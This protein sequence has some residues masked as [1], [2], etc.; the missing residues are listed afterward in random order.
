MK[1]SSA[2]AKGRRLAQLVRAK[3]LECAKDLEGGDIIVT[4][5][6]VTGEDVILSPKAKVQIP[7]AIECKNQE[8]VNVWD[9]FEQAK[10][11]PKNGET[12]LL[13]IARNRTEPLAVISL[14]A[15]LKILFR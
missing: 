7:F 10:T 9:A 4:P 2:K 8:R 5:S 6:S 14:E 11:H 13:V 1:T 12:P 3:L 15:F